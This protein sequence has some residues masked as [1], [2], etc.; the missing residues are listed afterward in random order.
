MP[1]ISVMLK[2]A[3]ALCNLQCRYCFYHDLAK[4]RESYSYGMMSL[5]TLENVLQKAFSYA[6]GDRV[7]LSFQGGE[8]TLCGKDFFAFAA[9]GIK[10]FRGKSEVELALQTNATLL[11]DETIEL[12]AQYDYLVGVSIDGPPALNALRLD[13]NGNPTSEATLRNAKRLLERGVRVNILCVVTPEVAR[14]IV[15]VY[16]Y[17]VDLGFRNLQF[18]PCLK[19]FGTKHSR[20]CLTAKQYSDY[21]FDLFRCYHADFRAGQYVSVRQLDNFVRRAH[22]LPADQC[23]Q[24]GHCSRQFVVE[25]DGSVFPC[26]FYCLDE[27]RLGNI[28]DTDTDFG[29]LSH[30]PK[31]LAFLQ[32]ST[33]LP[34]RCKQCSYLQLCG[35]G[36]K[37]ERLDLD[38]C[39]GHKRLF[40]HALPYLKAMS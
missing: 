12:L 21:L 30:H 11:D 20:H 5:A 38:C 34:E 8:P 26:D 1:P 32:E 16:R 24:N 2:P 22:G 14:N 7:Y 17:F 39:Q 31:A 23:G 13:R 29:R 28:N 10:R 36:C 37:R 3:S 25:G 27:Y 15:E 19:P 40:A 35:N 4:H 33:V 6:D 9:E 18:I